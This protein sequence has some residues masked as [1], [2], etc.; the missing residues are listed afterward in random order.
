M[1]AFERWR[2]RL[3]GERVQLF[4]ARFT[5]ADRHAIEQDVLRRFGKESSPGERAGRLL[6]ATQVVEQSLDLDF[7]TL[8]SDLAPIDLLVQRAGRLRRHQRSASG[9]R[10]AGPDER[11]EP[12]LHVFSPAALPE[13]GATWFS[14]FLPGAARVYE[15]HGRL[16]AGARWLEQHGRLRVPEDLREVI[17]AV[18]APVDDLEVP[19][20]LAEIS[21]KAEGKARADS[22]TAGLN[23]ISFRLGYEPSGM[24]SSWRDDVLTPTRLGDPTVTLRLGRLE[25]SEVVPLHEGRH[26][27]QLS[28]VQVR[29]SLV[30]AEWPGDA[31]LIEKAKAGMRDLGKWSLLIVLRSGPSGLT[32]EAERPGGRPVHIFYSS[33]CG[34]EV[35]R[36]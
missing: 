17:E 33:D 4:H 13:A 32:A 14:S 34:L 30:A 35:E 9:E 22:S 26:G 15:D 31:A 8:V 1:A 16:W 19:A 10:V 23:R 36:P 21:R 18:Y 27:W 28:E 12:V 11:G 29:Q 2:E 3:G 20:A 25:G 5:V 6:I 7:D 24:V